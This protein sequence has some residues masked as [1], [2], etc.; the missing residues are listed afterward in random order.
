MSAVMK[1]HGKRGGIK[2]ANTCLV[3]VLFCCLHHLFCLVSIHGH[4]LVADDVLSCLQCSCG[5]DSMLDS[6]PDNT[7]EGN[8][9]TSPSG[10][11]G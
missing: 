11:E 2:R 3:R 7:G 1:G 4:G 8:L 6:T 10:D 9:N 5:M